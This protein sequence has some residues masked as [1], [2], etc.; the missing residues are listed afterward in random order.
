MSPWEVSV[1]VIAA[2]FMHLGV[3]MFGAGCAMGGGLTLVIG[4]R[5][6][7]RN[8]KRALWGGLALIA[9]NMMFWAIGGTR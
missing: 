4:P 7:K 2:E 9:A 1:H 6:W 5:R 8:G 3:I